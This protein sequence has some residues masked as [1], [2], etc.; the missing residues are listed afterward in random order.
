MLWS[1]SWK[2]LTAAGTLWLLSAVWTQAA[3][4]SLYDMTRFLNEPHPFARNTAPRVSPDTPPPPPSSPARPAARQLTARPAAA[5]PIGIVSEIR[6]GILKHAIAF[7]HDAKETG[8]DAN[9]EVLFNS[10]DWWIFKALW[11]PRPHIGTSFNTSL[12]NTDQ[13]YAGLTWEW[14]PVSWFFVDLGLGL[15]VHNGMLDNSMIT[16]KSRYDRREFGCR[17]LFREALD[18]GWRITPNHSLSL[19][20]SHI[21][22]GGLCHEENE[23]MDNAGIRYGYRF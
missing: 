19:M 14:S 12:T 7:G 23:G 6:G 16:H 5:K 21:S 10:P 22:H 9:L 8:V 17:V 13:I 18:I 1:H 4:S 20:W 2:S 15:T 3:A 11:E